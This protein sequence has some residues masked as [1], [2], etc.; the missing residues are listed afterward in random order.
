MESELVTG[1]DSNIGGDNNSPPSRYTDVF[2]QVCP[3]YLS[4]GMTWEQFWDG[5]NPC[6]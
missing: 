2:E 5:D 1:S 6:G 4:I 3:F